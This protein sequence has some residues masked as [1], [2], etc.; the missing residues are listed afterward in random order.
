MM[1]MASSTDGERNTYN[2]RAVKKTQ[3]AECRGR[4]PGSRQMGPSDAQKLPWSK[5]SPEAAE[6]C[7]SYR[8]CDGGNQTSCTEDKGQG[9][10]PVSSVSVYDIEGD[11][12]RKE[13]QRGK[14]E[15]GTR[16]G[17]WKGLQHKSSLPPLQLNFFP[18]ISTPSI[19]EG[20]SFSCFIAQVSEPR[21]ACRWSRGVWRS[22]DG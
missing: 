10:H 21:A 14:E 5:L 22:L 12:G 1:R 15:R 19:K 2:S 13:E 20:S 17:A 7:S 8:A 3:A 18:L 6:N 9:C 11:K 4:R 16:K